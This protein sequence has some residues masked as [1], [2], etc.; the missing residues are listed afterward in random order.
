MTSESTPIDAFQEQPK[1][2]SQNLPQDQQLS[3]AQILS[4]AKPHP[5]EQPHEQPQEKQKEQSQEKPQEQ[6]QK[7]PQ[8][9]PKEQLQTQMEAPPKPQ[10]HDQ[11]YQGQF[12][13]DRPPTPVVEDK[14][15]GTVVLQILGLAVAIALFTVVLA[16]VFKRH[17]FAA[18]S[19][20]DHAMCSSSACDRL[21]GGLISSIQPE[22]DPCDDFYAYVCGRYTGMHS[23]G[24][25][26][27]DM[28]AE[29]WR[30]VKD[31]VVSGTDPA[32]AT[33]TTT[34]MPSRNSLLNKIQALFASCL[35]PPVNDST[36]P[37]KVFVD[38]QGLGFSGKATAVDAVLIMLRLSYLYDVQSV[39]SAHLLAVMSQPRA[40]LLRASVNRHYV[41][42]LGDKPDNVSF[43]YHVLL[44]VYGEVENADK[45]VQLVSATENVVRR[46]A[47]SAMSANATPLEPIL[48]DTDFR[49]YGN[50]ATKT[51]LSTLRSSL[52]PDT[53]HLLVSWDV[54]RT[55][56]P[57][58]SPATVPG[59]GGTRFSR[60]W[61]LVQRSLGVPAVMTYLLHNLVPNTTEA[62]HKMTNEL[63]ATYNALFSN[64][65]FIWNSVPRTT[66]IEFQE[67]QATPLFFPSGVE[68]KE[69][70]D[71]FYEAYP[72]T[73]E[74]DSFL[75]N[76]LTV[77][78]LVDETQRN[79]SGLDISIMLTP[80][81]MT[82]ASATTNKIVLPAPALLLPLFSADAL[83]STNFAGLGHVL[84]HGMLRKLHNALTGPGESNGSAVLEPYNQCVQRSSPIY[85]PSPSASDAGATSEIDS[86]ADLVGLHVSYEAFSERL[87]RRTLPY[88][89]MTEQQVFFAM[90][91]FKFCR[92]APAMQR[93]Q[94][95]TPTSGQDAASRA[96]KASRERCN[97]PLR[98]MKAF[99]DAFKCRPSSP[100]N[101][102][103]KCTFW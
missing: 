90:H 27:S 101:P 32:F 86:V 26:F 5:Q 75:E 52:S 68:S 98:N 64:E 65:A 47:M 46:S 45:V 18:A 89:N 39:L 85:D 63:R 15:F 91:C 8:E 1:V 4:Q 31:K 6:P 41:R 25:V 43:S 55:M 49:Y 95:A 48:E 56:A 13:P 2:E 24:D 103:R 42:W 51:L 70:L 72:Y 30:L 14:T 66:L 36:A 11:P 7:E 69:Q 10:L 93:L 84:A 50:G 78:R 83:A 12:Q 53:L 21:A 81:A 19:G 97:A 77:H 74:D 79:A 100:M 99:A 96:F 61:G 58:V 23:T 92:I 80:N 28:E 62:L 29:L 38:S 71:A 73:R 82:L 33:V 22:L 57:V 9:Q 67:L 20:P 37:L 17:K 88:T 54:V 76:W 40:V 87:Q 3:Q 59:E 94:Y 34:P 16:F 102:D 44:D 60:C 35:R